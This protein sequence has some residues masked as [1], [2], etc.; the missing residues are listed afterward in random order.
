MSLFPCR[1]A[2]VQPKSNSCAATIAA[3][4]SIGITDTGQFCRVSHIAARVVSLASRRSLDP[5][6]KTPA[7]FLHD[8]RR[9][10]GSL[11][12]MLRNEL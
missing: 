10:E 11:A 12:G 8:A 7:K 6:F 1:N 5:P 2:V 3:V 4:N 9:A